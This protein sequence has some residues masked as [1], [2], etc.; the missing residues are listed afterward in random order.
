M[1]RFSKR[2]TLGVLALALIGPAAQAEGAEVSGEIAV[3]DEIVVYTARRIVTMEDSQPVATAVAV[4]DGWILSVGSEAS[5]A[6]WLE[7]QP[8]RIDRRFEQ[9][10][11]LPGLIDNHLHPLL[12]ALL[13][14]M[15]FITPEDWAL[16]DG[17]HDG[18]DGAEAYRARLRA[19]VAAHPPGEWFDTWGHH[20]LFHG[21]ITRADLDEISLER[22][23]VVWHRSFHETVLNSKAIELAGITKEMVGDHPQVDFEKGHFYETGNA[24]SIR[25]MT[26]RL[27]APERFGRGL[28]ILRALVHRGG[29]TTMADMATGLMT[30][31]VARDTA[32]IQQGLSDDDVPFR[33]WLVGAPATLASIEEGGVAAAR[34]EIEAAPGTG[35]DR[36]RHLRRHVKLLAD[37]AFFSQL[38]QMGPPGYIDGHQGEWLMEPPV[39][40]AA[41]R[42]FWNAGYTLH[43]HANGDAGVGATLDVLAKLQAE[44][45]RT[46]HRLTLHHY[47]FSTSEQAVRLASLGAAVSANPNYVYVLGDRYGTHGLGPDRASQMVRLGA[48]KRAGVSVSLH[49]DL[50]MA[51]ASPL[52]LAWVA[53][54]RL[55]MDGTLH[56]PDERLTAKEAIAAVTIDAAFPLGLENEIGSIRAGKRAD[57]TVVDRDP[58]S[59]PVSKWLTVRV[60]ATVFGGRTFPVEAGPPAAP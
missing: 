31:S 17:T 52:F 11:L 41:A 34:A 59:T 1:I 44:T 35:S 3:P 21:P 33:T 36:V 19:A 55:S 60:L 57:F 23:I 15:T 50:T 18:V 54:N 26:P 9:D 37:G 7:G 53:A 6:P 8:H 25:A 45:P 16:P 42:E 28:A 13:L 27:F 12:G 43:I 5:M 40:E 2:L 22:P 56:A 30:G 14:P 4:R 10:T 24:I 47:G 38:M 49:S 39:L 51:P 46:D 58:L 48:L 32:L 20:Q 29:I